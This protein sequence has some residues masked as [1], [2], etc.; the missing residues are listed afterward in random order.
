MRLRSGEEH[1]IKTGAQNQEANVLRLSKMQE[2]AD[3][4]RLSKMQEHWLP[5][6]VGGLIGKKLDGTF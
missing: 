4:F 2:S 3:V 6:V 5:Q 1:R